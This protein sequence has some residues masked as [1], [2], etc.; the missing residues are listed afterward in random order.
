MKCSCC[1]KELVSS[2]R[3]CPNCGQ[4]NDYYVEPKKKDINETPI[5]NQ[6]IS[7]TPV[8]NQTYDNQNSQNYNINSSQN[9]YQQTPVVVQ[10]QDVEGSSIAICAVVFG[11]LGG[12]LGLVLGIVGLC[13]YKEKGNRVMCIIGILSW[14]IWLVVLLTVFVR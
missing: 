4:N 14:V 3:F 9:S 6:P 7:T 2:D 5:V 1:G 8:K 13:R 12:W 10:Q 11:A